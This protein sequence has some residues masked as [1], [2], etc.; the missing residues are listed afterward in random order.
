MTVK[1]ENEETILKIQEGIA[2][3]GACGVLAASRHNGHNVR[4]EWNIAFLIMAH[5]VSAAPRNDKNHER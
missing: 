2:L 4:E 3:R 5:T 1:S